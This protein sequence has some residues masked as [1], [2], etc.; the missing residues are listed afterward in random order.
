[1]VGW[2]GVQSR[3]KENEGESLNWIIVILELN[4]DSSKLILTAMKFNEKINQQD[5]EGLAE[6][7]TTDHIFVDNDGRATRD[8]A[9][10]KEGWRNF[11]AQYPDYRNNF[12]CVTVQDKTV[13]MVGYLPAPPNRFMAQIYG[14]LRYVVDA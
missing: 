6:L 5:L 11:F 8:K 2:G 14:L 12:N 3:P 10:M 4:M 13:V 7:M 1:L 9:A